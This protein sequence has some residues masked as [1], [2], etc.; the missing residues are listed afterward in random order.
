MKAFEPA[1]LLR[2]A[3]LD[4][5]ERKPSFSHQTDNCV[6]LPAPVEANGGP[7]SERIASGRPN[8]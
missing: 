1:I 5:L 8:S 6:S 2:L 7:L 4:S 3:G